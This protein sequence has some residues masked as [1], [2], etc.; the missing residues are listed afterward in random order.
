MQYDRDA[1]GNMTPLPQQN[2]DTGMFPNA[3]PAS[4]GVEQLRTDSSTIVR[5]DIEN[6]MATTQTTCRSLRIIPRSCFLLAAACAAGKQRPLRVAP[7]RRAARTAM[8][9]FGTGGVTFCPICGESYPWSSGRSRRSSARK[10]FTL[11]QGFARTRLVAHGT[12]PASSRLRRLSPRHLSAFPRPR[13]S[14]GRRSPR[15]RWVEANSKPQQARRD[16]EGL[17]RSPRFCAFQR[18]G[19]WLTGCDEMTP[20]LRDRR[21]RR[22]EQAGKVSP[23]SGNPASRRNGQWR[24]GTWLFDEAEMTLPNRA[25]PGHHCNGCNPRQPGMPCTVHR[26]GT[27]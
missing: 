20:L 17:G 18:L 23:S 15:P 24:Q 2:I 12:A 13:R 22:S 26:S 4:W 8:L 16:L 5:E 27:A 11:H 21:W 9:G 14:R 7:I 6:P 25:V 1:S 3:L 19:A 10:A